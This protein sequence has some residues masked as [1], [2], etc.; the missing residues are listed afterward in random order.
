MSDNKTKRVIVCTDIETTKHTET[1]IKIAVFP[2]EFSR[3]ILMLTAAWVAT[4]VTCLY[5]QIL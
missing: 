4:I 3:K 2:G 5:T 1:K